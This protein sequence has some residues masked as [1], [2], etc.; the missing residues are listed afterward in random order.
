M[1]KNPTKKIALGTG[2]TNN[3]KAMDQNRGT[4]TT[5]GQSHKR[6][7]LQKTTALPN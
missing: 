5:S 4:K 7:W 2:A 3:I 6:K 1:A